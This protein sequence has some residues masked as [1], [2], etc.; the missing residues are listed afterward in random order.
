MINGV[1]WL[2]GS[3]LEDIESLQKRA[4]RDLDVVTIYWGYDMPFQNNLMAVFPDFADPG[5]SK[6]NFKLDHYPFD[7][8]ADPFLV[9]EYSR[10]W[11]QLFSHNRNS[12]WKGMLSVEI[13]TSVIDSNA[14]QY[15]NSLAI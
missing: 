3:F 4:P 6:T 9:V 10:Y 8:S 1:Q 2:D 7:A 12:V 15:L 13:N 14:L 11:T 5:L